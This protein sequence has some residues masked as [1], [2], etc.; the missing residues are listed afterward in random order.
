VARKTSLLRLTPSVRNSSGIKTADGIG[1][2]NSI[3]T[4]NA[5][6]AKSLEPSRIPIGIASAGARNS[7][8]AQP[9][10][11]RANAPQKLVGSPRPAVSGVWFVVATVQSSLTVVLIAGRSV[12]EITPVRDT[13]SHRPSTAAT[14]SAGS[15]QRAAVPAIERARRGAVAAIAVKARSRRVP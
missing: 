5:A 13:S 7:P 10:T 15:S 1:R 11:V 3:G 6:A 14:L 8:I 2:R 4:R 12:C 9:R